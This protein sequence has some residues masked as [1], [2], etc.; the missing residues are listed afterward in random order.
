ME[1]WT[2]VTGNPRLPWIL[3]AMATAAGITGFALAFMVIVPRGLVGDGGEG[4]VDAHAYWVAGRNILAG[5]DLY[6]G[7]SGERD[8]YLYP[9]PFAQLVAPAAGLLPAVAFVWLW[10]A[11]SVA[12]LIFAAGGWRAA[13][14]ALL[15]FPPAIVE[16]EAGNVSF[17]LA[18]ICALVM[19][20]STAALPFAFVLKLAGGA[21][22]LFALVRDW[23]GLVIGA[24]VAGVV[25]AASFLLTPWLWMDYAQFLSTA[26]PMEYWTNLG[27]DIPLILRLAV[28][29]VVGV[30]A[31]RWVV[32]LPVAFVL[33]MP[34]LALHV[35]AI[36]VCMAVPVSAWLKDRLGMQRAAA[37]VPA[38]ATAVASQ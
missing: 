19:R 28:A 6:G 2:A 24:A 27:R 30:L 23:R 20:G 10:R 8:A 29:G 25:V 5:A 33:S 32:L 1:A 15:I 17:Q 9:P 18:A 38:P 13:G 21:A 3:G 37:P 31:I 7:A 26:Q 36:L 35:L 22:A 14:I 12:C 16:L 4:G 11:V 34:I